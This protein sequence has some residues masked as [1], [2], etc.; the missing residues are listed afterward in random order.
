MTKKQV[1]E[2]LKEM[3]CEI[4]KVTLKFYYVNHMMTMDV[5]VYLVDQ[6]SNADQIII[7]KHWHI[8]DSIDEFEEFESCNFY[9]KYVE[10]LDVTEFLSDFATA[11]DD[12][13]IDPVQEEADD[14][15]TIQWYKV[16]CSFFKQEFG[17]RKWSDLIEFM[18][19]TI[20]FDYT[21]TGQYTKPYTGVEGYY[22]DGHIIKL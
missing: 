2:I 6:P 20:G 9:G 7:C 12:K 5:L 19:H 11:K 21:I 17:V 10:F 22:E 8:L 16:K 14:I 3:D 13:K 18:S 15:K 4:A 1:V